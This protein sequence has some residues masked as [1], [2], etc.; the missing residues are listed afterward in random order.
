MSGRQVVVTCGVRVVGISC[1]LD[2]QPGAYWHVYTSVTAIR[3]FDG[4]P[5]MSTPE[6]TSPP[7]N[8]N[9][10]FKFVFSSIFRCAY[11]LESCRVAARAQNMDSN[12][13]IK[14]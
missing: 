4:Q 12:W 1:E 13:A 6:K 11:E 14:R 7:L 2:P 5:Q 8:I 10:C 9:V 3:I